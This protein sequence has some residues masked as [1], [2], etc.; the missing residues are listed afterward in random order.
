MSFSSASTTVTRS[1][2]LTIVKDADRSTVSEAGQVI[3][4]TITVDNTG[5]VDLTGVVLTDAFAGG[6]TLTSTGDAILES[7]RRMERLASEAVAA[8]LDLLASLMKPAP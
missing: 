7:Y 5:N 6:A 3:T 4:Y 2:A 1:A 8:E